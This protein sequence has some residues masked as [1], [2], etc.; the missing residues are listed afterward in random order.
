[1]DLAI[2]ILT[3]FDF[4]GELVPANLAFFVYFG[5]FLVIFGHFQYP[6]KPISAQNRKWGLGGQKEW[7]LSFQNQL[8][9]QCPRLAETHESDPKI[10]YF[11]PPKIWISR[12]FFEKNYFETYI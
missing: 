8:R 3:I 7:Y 10:A 11:R 1:M 5:Y 12:L 6:K 2:C 9:N 4:F